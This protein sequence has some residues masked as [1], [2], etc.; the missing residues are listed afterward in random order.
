MNPPAVWETWVPSLD[1]EDPL[2]KEMAPHTSFLVWK[3][4]L[5]EEPG[6]PQSRDLS[7]MVEGS[8]CV[9]STWPHAS[10]ST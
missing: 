8:R 6:G 3:I 10:R 4:P 7:G 2:E 9:L 5:T 1:L